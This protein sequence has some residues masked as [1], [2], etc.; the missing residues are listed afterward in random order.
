MNSNEGRQLKGASPGDWLLGLIL[1]LLT[2]AG[3]GVG[4]HLEKD[5]KLY[6][7]TRI[8]L[9]EE[10]RIVHKK[11]LKYELDDLSEPKPNSKLWL[12]IYY[13]FGNPDK[14]GGIGNFIKR[15]F[16]E[17]PVF[18]DQAE[19]DRNVLA[20]KKYLIDQGYFS[21][22][23]Q[24]DTSQSGK[25]VDVTYRINTSGRHQ[26]RNITLP[27]DSSNIAGIIREINDN[28]YLKSG[29][30]YALSK[31][32]NERN[33]IAV[34]ARNR[35]YFDFT[36]EKIFYFVDTNAVKDP[37]ELVSDIWLQIKTPENT[38]DY[39]KYYIGA[40][41]IYPNYD[42]ARAASIRIIDSTRY[43]DLVIYQNKQIVR[44]ST[45]RRSITQKQGEVFSE[46]R[47]IATSN[48]LLDLGIYK[49]VNLK[50]RVR[51]AGDTSFLDR[52]IYLTPGK[53]Q[54]VGAALETTTRAGAYG[55]SVRGSY[56][57]NNIFGGAERL[58]LSVSTGFER[59]GKIAI[60]DD[61]LNNN[62]KEI[63]ARA[64]LSFPRFIL[65]FIKINSSSTF[66]VPRT[67]LGVLANYQDRP[68]LFTLYNYRFTFG[69]D[70]D[71]TRR[72][73]HQL[74]LL[75]INTVR[76]ARK[77]ESFNNFLEQ[78][79]L[80]KR[81]FANLFI[82]GSTYTYTLTNQEINRPDNYFFFLGQ[83][84]ASGNTAYLGSLLFQEKTSEPF[85]IFKKEFSQFTKLDFDYRYNWLGRKA[86]LVT[87]FS[88]GI[89][90]AYLN[91]VSLPIIK[92]YF[93]GGA[94]SMR[95]F[96]IRG[97]LGSSATDGGSEIAQ[98]SFDHTGD[99]KIE[100]NIEYRFDLLR[101]LYLKGA[102][103][104]D[105]GNVWKVN[106]RDLE[107]N[108]SKLFA[109]DRL[110][111]ELAVAGGI[112]VRLDI[113]YLVLRLDLG[114][115]LRKPFLDPGARWTFDRIGTRGWIRDN[116]V[117]NFALGYPF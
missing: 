55:I 103:F 45:L 56:S 3:C 63:T 41:H 21:S 28:S 6:N 83:L 73:R 22:S 47:Q 74:N 94:N 7:D 29:D 37:E 27:V 88:G 71:E 102:V 12:W 76:I 109:A 65:P 53:V 115:P 75:S 40:T 39:L 36:D 43:D 10:A 95:G 78:N 72:K 107:P 31:L 24:F 91:S 49:F 79:P 46:E 70:W 80:L 116:L 82:I 64:D 14:E 33:R 30:Y 112:G 69:Y 11:Q 92:Q 93:A 59:G 81:S 48:H 1:L 17:A 68:E 110:L 105:I 13:N 19:I 66:H 51:P 2:S 16:G 15:R 38:D 54:N 104:A 52:Y 18:Y 8:V 117:F 67:R 32:V 114:L 61:T 9:E 108:K 111:S 99:L 50:Y 97:L 20:L 106:G 35:G 4:K 101:D 44:P 5:Q 26:I 96:P 90:L 42:L 25:N 85:T 86:N 62:L 100:W 60:T 89:G 77:S 23:V 87:K 34:E 57:H 84:E 58:D 113:Q 98:S